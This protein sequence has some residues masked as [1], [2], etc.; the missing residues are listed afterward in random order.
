M[1]PLAAL[2][3]IIDISGTAARIEAKLPECGTGS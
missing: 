2:E 3:E 1:I